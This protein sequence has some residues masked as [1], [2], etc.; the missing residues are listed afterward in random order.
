MLNPEGTLRTCQRQVSTSPCHTCKTYYR[1]RN[2]V[3]RIWRNKAHAAWKVGRCQKISTKAVYNVVWRR[4]APRMCY[5]SYCWIAWRWNW[6]PDWAVRI[7]IQLGYISQCQNIRHQANELEAKWF[8]DPTVGIAHC[9]YNL[10]W[11]NG[12]VD[13]LQSIA[14]HKI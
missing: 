12:P 14:V 2:M 1:E 4:L 11:R 5:T 10:W 9:K 8:P 6:H 7:I 13:A 3:P